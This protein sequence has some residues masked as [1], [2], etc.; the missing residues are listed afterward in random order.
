[1]NQTAKSV[2]PGIIAGV[3]NYAFIIPLISI[4]AAFYPSFSFVEKL[5]FVNMA[6]ILF[7]ILLTLRHQY[8][9]QRMRLIRIHETDPVYLIEKN[10]ARHIPDPGTFDYLGK[11]Y[12]FHWKDVEVITQGE[13]KNQF[14]NGSALPSILPHCQ[15]FYEQKI[16]QDKQRRLIKNE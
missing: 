4:A 6:L 7:A 10:T 16:E 15:A 11:L 1:M 12:G 14:S 3:I 5:S 9:P 2:I 13:F 8:S